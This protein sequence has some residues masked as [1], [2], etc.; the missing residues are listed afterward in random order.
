MQSRWSAQKHI[1]TSL[2][3]ITTRYGQLRRDHAC[4]VKSACA[5]WLNAGEESYIHQQLTQHHPRIHT[6][7]INQSA[8]L[9]MQSNVDLPI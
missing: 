3:I 9:S 8:M 4:A 7:M 2:L 1:A 5:P 6:Q